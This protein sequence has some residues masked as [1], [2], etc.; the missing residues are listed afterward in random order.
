MTAFIHTTKITGQMASK[1][2]KSGY[3]QPLFR[4]TAQLV[5][6]AYSYQQVHK[7]TDHNAVNN[8]NK[9]RS[10]QWHDDKGFG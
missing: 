6:D 4:E 9:E 10:R 8:I 2:Y 3:L 7:Q 1:K 5:N